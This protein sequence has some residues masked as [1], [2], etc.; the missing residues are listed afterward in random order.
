[1][2]W[3]ARKG[4]AG[5]GL[6]S[7]VRQSFPMNKPLWPC[8]CFCTCKMWDT[9]QEGGMR[10]NQEPSNAPSLMLQSLS[11]GLNS[12]E[13]YSSQISKTEA[14][15][16]SIVGVLRVCLSSYLYACP[17]VAHS[18]SWLTRASKGVSHL[19]KM[20][21]YYFQQMDL[22]LLGNVSAFKWQQVR[23]SKRVENM[24]AHLYRFTCYMPVQRRSLPQWFDF[25]T[26][27]LLRLIKERPWHKWKDPIYSSPGPHLLR[28]VTEAHA[29]WG[30]KTLPLGQIP[31][32]DT[33]VGGFPLDVGH[34]ELLFIPP[35]L[36]PLT[37][38]TN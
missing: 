11:Q 10:F 14:N 32:Q 35:L 4:R 5:I 33:A 22:M 31:L 16:R 3:S 30:T 27:F 36:Y 20:V 12:E 18:N 26:D 1:M 34:I 7:V 21:S 15:G 9:S 37:G 8:L 2:V 6:N 17:P 28:S 23:T 29:W 13:L 38:T 25:T 19:R 24:T